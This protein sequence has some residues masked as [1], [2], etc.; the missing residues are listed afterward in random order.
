VV[1]RWEME[2]H[3]SAI[4]KSVRPERIVE[5]L[6]IFDFALTAEE[7]AVI[8]ALDTGER[9]GPDPEKV[10]TALFT[11]SVEEHYRQE[12]ADSDRNTTKTTT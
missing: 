4:P 11:K 9:G 7:V 8:D 2:L 1:L 3:L 6:A 5:N 12:S 10:D